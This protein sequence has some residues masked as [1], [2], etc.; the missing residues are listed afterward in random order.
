MFYKDHVANFTN[1][2][3]K[4]WLPNQRD[5]ENLYQIGSKMLSYTFHC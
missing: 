2:Q 5:R 3:K 4:V 1:T